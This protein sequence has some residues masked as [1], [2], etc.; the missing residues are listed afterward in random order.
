MSFRVSLQVLRRQLLIVVAGVVIGVAVGWVSAPGETAA[1]TRF[2]AIHTLIYETQRGQ[3]YQIEQG[4][5]L[6]ATGAV[7]SRV[8][9]RLGMERGQVRSAV[10]AV[11]AAARA[12]ADAGDSGRHRGR[13]GGRPGSRLQGGPGVA[14]A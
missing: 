10:S 2:K 14:A 8:A 13:A 7:P 12:A 1:D 3:T 4:A 6:A 9:A 11:A 5:F